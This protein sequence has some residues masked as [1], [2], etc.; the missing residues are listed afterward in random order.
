MPLPKAL[1]AKLA[2]RGIIKS[3]PS[4]TKE[5]EPDVTNSVQEEIIAEDYDEN[6]QDGTPIPQP[7]P[8]PPEKFDKFQGWYSCPNKWNV[9]HECS[10]ACQ[11]QWK[12]IKEI[13]KDY[14]R[15]RIKLLIKYPLPPHWQEILDIGLRRYYY[16]NTET[17]LVSWLPPGHPKCRVSASAAQLRKQMFE[18]RERRLKEEGD[19]KKESDEEESSDEEKGVKK[20]R[21]LSAKEE[22][23]RRSSDE[24]S[25]ESVEEG[26]TSKKEKRREKRD[27]DRDRE[28][29]KDKDRDRDRDRDRGRD[30]DAKERR[31][32]E[33]SREKRGTKRKE[34]ADA[35]DPMDPA[36]YSDCPRGT[37]AS[38]LPDKNE[39]K[40]G[41]D[42][43]ATGPLFQM[44]PYPNPGAVLRANAAANST[45]GPKKPT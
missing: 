24:S 42:S 38:G 44:R 23:D 37:W 14:S 10:P 27:K 15:K 29:D 31:G 45:V 33:R 9:Y 12:E 28:R 3:S 16:W 11:D 26:K 21:K 1:A 41:V 18:E 17:D 20:R 34:D 8:P 22:A 39:A 30:R 35:L 7:P 6:P 2:K 25:A 40:T 43:T 32:K 4:Q 19:E 5:P 36:A 13:D